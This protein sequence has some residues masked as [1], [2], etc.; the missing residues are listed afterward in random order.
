MRNLMSAPFY[1]YFRQEK[2]EKPDSIGP[3]E[4]D[5][6]SPGPDIDGSLADFQFINS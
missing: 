1:A 4:P 3:F 5:F 2:Q 6:G